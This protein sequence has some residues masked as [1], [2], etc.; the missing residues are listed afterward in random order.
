MK[1]N[2]K[3][4]PISPVGPW[5][6]SSG[7]NLKEVREA[8]NETISSKSE[9]KCCNTTDPYV[10]GQTVTLL[11]LAGH[12][13]SL[14]QKDDGI[15]AFQIFINLRP[16]CHYIGINKI[17]GNANRVQFEQGRYD[18]LMELLGKKYNW[19]KDAVKADKA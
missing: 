1:L 2:K 3:L 11:E 10:A 13:F 4:L 15:Y 19:E 5:R 9:A 12:S 14:D 17:D 8:L 7:N 18:A 16:D 6:M